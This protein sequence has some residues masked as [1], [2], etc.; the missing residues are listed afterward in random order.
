[1]NNIV[2]IAECRSYEAD[3]VETA[4]QKVLEPFGELEFVR[5]GARIIIKANLVSMMKPDSAATTHPALLCA[6][7]KYLTERGA[8]VV[9]GDSP[10]G[11]YTSAYV[12]AV[13]AATGIKAATSF[14]AVLNQ[15]FEHKHALNPDGCVLKELDY[16]SYLDEADALINFCKLKTHGMMGMS[17]CVKNLFG[18]IP[19]TFKPEYHYKFSTHESFANMLV[20][21]NER[22]KPSLCIV[23][24]VVGMEGNGPTMGKPRKIGCILASDSPYACDSVC[25]QIIGIDPDE[26]ETVNAARKRG[27]EK[28]FE[29]FGNPDEFKVADFDLV[30]RRKDMSFN[31]ELPGAGGKLLGHIIKAALCSRPKVNKRECVLCGKCAAVC[32][33]KAITIKNKPPQIDKSKCIRCFCCQEFCPK[34]AMRVHRPLAAKILNK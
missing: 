26:L 25:A 28:E 24:A 29:L 8:N 6:L 19:G 21:I 33:A 18:C 17:A 3:V 4:L 31:H 27:L 7:T 9:I 22:F 5:P 34:G 1:M 32:P 16:T 23:D 20:D 11:L 30:R 10:G 12:N 15:N 2:S 14:G 13:Y